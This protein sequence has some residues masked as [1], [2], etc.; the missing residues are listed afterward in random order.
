MRLLP[1]TNGYDNRQRPERFLRLYVHHQRQLHAYVAA[2][3]ANPVDVEEV[4]HDTTLVLW[5]R[6]AEFAVDRSFLAW[7]CGVAGN[8][9]RKYYRQ[10]RKGMLFLDE[11]FLETLSIER[12]QLADLLEERRDALKACLQKLRPDDR[13]LIEAYY[14]RKGRTATIA[15]QMGRPIN[16]IHKSL[17]RIRSALMD[18][19]QRSLRL[20][21]GP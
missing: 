7:A 5:R 4:L 14:S 18:C 20:Q 2:F 1:E 8:Q 13:S 10:R 6:F 11:S 15:E 17:G 3:V 9:I 19:V 21:E 16:S 12:E